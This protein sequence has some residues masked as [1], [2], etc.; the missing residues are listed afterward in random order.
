MMESLITIQGIPMNDFI[1]ALASKLNSRL[2]ETIKKI[3]SEEQTEKLLSSSEVCSL[4]KISKPT[5]NAW[6]RDGRLTQYRIGK[7]VYYKYGEVLSS[8]QHLKKYKMAVA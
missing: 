4:L 3:L 8:M 7:R 2:E 6:S 1:D 5:L